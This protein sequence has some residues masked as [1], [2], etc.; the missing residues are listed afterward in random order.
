MARATYRPR[1]RSSWLRRIVLAFLGV[2]VVLPI[3]LIVLFRFVPPPI[4][5]TMAAVWITD[6]PVAQR[7]VPLA[8][9]SPNLIR[10]V[11][12]SEDGKFCSH[13]GFDF[14]AIDKALA[15]NA[16]GG[17]LRGASTISQQTAKNLFL[18]QNRTWTRKGIE[19]YLTVL[20]EALWPKRRIIETYL[21]IAE[22]GPRR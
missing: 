16:D 2:T 1:K 15:S 17:T 21:N 9:I 8:A 11:I 10:A 18:S 4:T 12:A 19:A 20:L 14:E 7:W 13:H 22:W 3:A 6:G 5:P